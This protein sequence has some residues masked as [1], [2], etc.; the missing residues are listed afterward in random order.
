M[1]RAACV[2]LLISL[3][4]VAVGCA[5]K[6]P[7]GIVHGEV[8]LDGTPLPNGDISFFSV[9]DRH[10][11][12]GGPIQDGKFRVKVPVGTVR[13]VIHSLLVVRPAKLP[14]EGDARERVPA[15]YNTNSGLKHDVTPGDNPVTFE[16]S[17]K[18]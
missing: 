16:L 10:A 13:V 1:R 6:H 4:C 2:V 15:K 18:P 8:R 17:S 12:A 9:D 14:D 5:E 3:L 11:P 7:E